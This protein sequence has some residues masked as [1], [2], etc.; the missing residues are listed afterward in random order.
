[1]SGILYLCATPI[2]NLSDCTPRVIETLKEVD[3]IACEDTRVTRKLLSHFDIHAKTT[4]YHEHNR[5]DKARELV[6]ILHA[7]KNI[8]LVTDAG[9]PAISDPGYELV[10]LCHDEGIA[11]TCLPGACALVTALSVSGIYPRRFI[12]E[13][14][15]PGKNEKKERLKILNQLKSEERTVILYEAPHHLK[16]LLDD[17]LENLGDRKISL[18]RELTKKFE[19]IRRTT[20]SAAVSFYQNN[21]PR[22]EYVIVIEGKSAEELEEQSREAFLELS[23]G[24][25]FEMYVN[26]GFD[27]KEAMKRVASDR[28]VSRR[29]IYKELFT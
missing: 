14:F 8:A 28:G 13:G 26:M 23:I 21:E 29:D 12:F 24:E 7:G 19:E 20:L 22:G 1:M 16:I 15:L 5:F 11:V 25:H 3:L 10:S 4:S 6:D 17:L 18:C 2:G 27:K 9:L